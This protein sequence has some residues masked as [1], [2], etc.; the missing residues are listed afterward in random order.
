MSASIELGII[1]ETVRT[2][3]AVKRN[4]DKRRDLK[5]LNKLYKR[6]IEDTKRDI[7]DFQTT[8]SYGFVDT[9]RKEVIKSI[10]NYIKDFQKMNKKEEVL[11]YQ[12]LLK[13]VDE[14]ES[15]TELMSILDEAENFYYNTIENNSEE[16][17]IREYIILIL[18]EMGI[19]DAIVDEDGNILSS[20]DENGDIVARIQNGKVKLDIKNNGRKC[21]KKINEFEKLT[22]NELMKESFVWH[23]EEN[24]KELN[25]I[26]ERSK[27]KFNKNKIYDTILIRNT[28]E[29][30]K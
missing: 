28:L 10:E 12:K 15:F 22:K 13:S 7:K 21:V 16:D 8:S 3:L 18:K 1:Y 6:E 4:L 23:T 17:D 20:S 5:K 27:H 14:T 11:K 24:E 9:Q 30:N 29:K 19:E 26:V 2:S 25:K